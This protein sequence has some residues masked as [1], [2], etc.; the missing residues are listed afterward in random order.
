MVAVEDGQLMRPRKRGGAAR[1]GLK[2]VG[3]SDLAEDRE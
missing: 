3:V 2:G 1:R